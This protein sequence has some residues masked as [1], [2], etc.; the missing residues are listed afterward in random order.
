MVGTMWDA[1]I[2]AHTVT[3]DITVFK[4]DITVFKYDFA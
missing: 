4:Y 1:V 2:I 3:R